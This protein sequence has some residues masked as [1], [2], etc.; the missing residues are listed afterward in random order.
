MARRLLGPTVL[1]V[2]DD[3]LIAALVERILISAGYGVVGPIPRL[4]A[5]QIA[6]SHGTFDVAV[7]DVNLNGERVYPAAEILTKRNVPYLFITGYA[8]NHLPA[9]F[10]QRPRI[11]KPFTAEELVGALSKL[12]RG[13]VIA[14]TAAA[15]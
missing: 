9:E 3:Y 12:L 13:P 2:E 1:I 8:G 6:A 5:A 11:N 10:A 4:F 7:L 15:A 14:A